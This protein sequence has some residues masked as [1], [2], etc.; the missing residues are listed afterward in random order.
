MTGSAALHV[1]S[2]SIQHSSQETIVAQPLS[3]VAI[4]VAVAGRE[5]E[6]RAAPEKLV[7][8]TLAEP[9]CLR[10]ELNE[11]LDDGRVLI[12][13][14][15]WASESDWRAHM[16]G[17]AMRRFSQIGAPSLIADFQLFRL[18]TVAGGVCTEHSTEPKRKAGSKLIAMFAAIAL[19]CTFALASN[20]SHAAS[21]EDSLLNDTLPLLIN[22]SELKWE[23]TIPA[24]GDKSPEYSILHV[25]P[26]TKLTMLMFRTPIDVHIKAHTHEL[27]ETHVVLS[28]GTHVFEANG[29]RYAIEKGGFLRMPG[30]IVHGPGCRQGPRRLTSRKANGS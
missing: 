2:G 19:A 7:A 17:S 4:S 28:G 13:T 22:S 26:K 29:A 30:G 10:Y 27:A 11:S 5:T 8:E 20:G 23:K 9:G 1:D 21:P 25:D 15:Q 3:I 12:F 24:L 18:N 14:E 16:E 6:L